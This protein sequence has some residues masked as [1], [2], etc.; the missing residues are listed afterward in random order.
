[1]LQKGF[2]SANLFGKCSIT[3]HTPQKENSPVNTIT[4]RK[5]TSALRI[6]PP[7]KAPRVS[8]IDD[9]LNGRI[10]QDMMDSLQCPDRCIHVN[11][12]IMSVLEARSK[13]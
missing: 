3:K 5:Y 12:G 2:S 6:T 4:K 1:M 7:Q 10:I 9:K 8:I 11:G 13:L